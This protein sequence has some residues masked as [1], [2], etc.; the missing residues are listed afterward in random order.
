MATDWY[1]DAAR[2]EHNQHC[3][4]CRQLTEA[5]DAAAAANGESIRRIDRR[6]LGLNIATPRQAVTV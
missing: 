3:T 6:Q 2:A 4:R 1:T 5:S